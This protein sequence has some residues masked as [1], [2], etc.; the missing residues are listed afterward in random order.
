M[1]N[2]FRKTLYNNKRLVFTVVLNEE[3][4]AKDPSSL[5]F[6]QFLVSCC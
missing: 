3:S 2:H 1:Y 5:F 6:K 4:K